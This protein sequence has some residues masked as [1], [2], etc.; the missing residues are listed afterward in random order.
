MET[1]AERML[2]EIDGPAGRLEAL[3]DEP[4]AARGVNAEGL[5]ESGGQSGVRAAAVIAHPHP[6]YGGTMH[7]KAVYQTAKA[8]ARIGCA[9]LRFNFRGVG[10]SAG[11][12]DHGEGERDDLR[13]ALQFMHDRYAGRPLWAGGMSFGAWAALDVGARD[14]RVSALIGLA[15][16]VTRYDF[17][18]V[19]DSSTPKFF[20][21][22]ERDEI[23]PIRSVREFY[24]HAREPKE[25][26]VID[27][28][29]H[30]FDG[31]TSEV[32]EAIEDLLAD[33]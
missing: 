11:A 8:L 12:F 33:W 30:V 6:Q 19:Q 7:T 26:V 3:L 22:G 2:R 25:L 18:A 21:H 16:P 27:G 29:D 5:V 31:K 32:S 23:A 14:G 24:A 15:L 9:V 13:A 20:I 28:A 4:A 17:S 1:G 10:T